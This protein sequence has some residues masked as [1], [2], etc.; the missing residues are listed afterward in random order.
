MLLYFI[1]SVRT[2]R[3]AKYTTLRA[4][5]PL[6]NGLLT[7][8]YPCLYFSCLGTAWPWL[9]IQVFVFSTLHTLYHQSQYLHRPPLIFWMSDI[10]LRIPVWCN[11]AEY[12]YELCSILTRPQGESEHKQRVIISN[13]TQQCH[14]PKVSQKLLTIQ[15]PCFIGISFFFSFETNHAGVANLSNRSLTEQNNKQSE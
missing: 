2:P 3:S 5:S 8:N 9:Q 15:L 4:G 10:D 6:L 11:I 7:K 12:F 1:H 13:N 14:A